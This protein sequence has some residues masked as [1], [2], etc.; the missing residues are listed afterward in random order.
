MFKPWDVV[1][2]NGVPVKGKINVSVTRIDPTT[3]LGR[4]QMPGNFTG[5]DNAGRA[6]DLISYVMMA[7]GLTDTDGHALET[8][9]SIQMALRVPE[10]L[11]ETAPQGIPL[12]LFK[13]AVKQ[14]Q[15]KG[16]AT[17]S[18]NNYKGEIKVKRKLPYWNCD[19][20]MLRRIRKRPRTQK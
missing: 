2:E 18:G 13:D 9:K 10:S 8:M 12:W 11:E 20:F 17:L 14:W 5:L 3:G 16:S 4:N 1:D 15:E 7:V 6:G 19:T